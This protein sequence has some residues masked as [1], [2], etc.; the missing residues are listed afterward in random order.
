MLQESIN[1]KFKI[2]IR[3]AAEEEPKF[4]FYTSRLGIGYKDIVPFYRKQIQENNQVELKMLPVVP[5]E[6]GAFVQFRPASILY[7]TLPVAAR[8]TNRPFP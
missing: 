5:V 6:L 2:G 3:I 4:E 7:A 1:G 8:A